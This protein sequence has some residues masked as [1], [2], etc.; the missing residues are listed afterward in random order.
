[1]VFE[2]LVD[3]PFF[4]LVLEG[5]DPVAWLVKVEDTEWRGRT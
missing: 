4:Q 1:M 2:V 3:I 5:T